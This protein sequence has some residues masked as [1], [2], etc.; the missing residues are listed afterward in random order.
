MFKD[1]DKQFQLDIDDII[2]EH[3]YT[4][5][6]Q[7]NNQEMAVD[8][9]DHEGEASFKSQTLDGFLQALMKSDGLSEK[10]YLWH[11]L[12]REVNTQGNYLNIDG[13]CLSVKDF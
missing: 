11:F 8:E 12:N 6:Q 9:H 7:V 1:D 3:F 5:V 2:E 4:C 13:H 10:N